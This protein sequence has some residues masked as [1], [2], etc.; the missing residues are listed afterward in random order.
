[1]TFNMPPLSKPFVVKDA[2]TL[3]DAQTRRDG[4]FFA[5]SIKYSKVAILRK[6]FLAY[7]E[8]CNDQK[9]NPLGNMIFKEIYKNTFNEDLPD[10]DQKIKE[11]TLDTALDLMTNR[12][13]PQHH[14]QNL[15]CLPDLRNVFEKYRNELA[16]IDENAFNQYNWTEKKAHIKKITDYNNFVLLDKSIKTTSILDSQHKNLK[17]MATQLEEIMTSMQSEITQFLSATFQETNNQ[18]NP[19]AITNLE[20]FFYTISKAFNSAAED[21]NKHNDHS[22]A[23]AALVN[24]LLKCQSFQPKVF[25]DR[26]YPI[27]VEA[28]ITSGKPVLLDKLLTRAESDEEGYQFLHTAIKNCCFVPYQHDIIAEITKVLLQHNQPI[29]GCLPILAERIITPQETT[30]ILSGILNGIEKQYNNILSK[31]KDKFLIPEPFAEQ[32]RSAKTLAEK[33]DALAA[34]K[35]TITTTTTFTQQIDAITTLQEQ[36]NDFLTALHVNKTNIYHKNDIEN[37]VGTAQKYGF[38]INRHFKE[39]I[40]NSDMSSAPKNKTFDE[41][42]KLLHESDL[43]PHENSTLTYYELLRQEAD[44]IAAVEHRQGIRVSAE[45][46][47]SALLTDAETENATSSVLP[48]GPS[49]SQA[50]AAYTA[51]AIGWNTVQR[52]PQPSIAYTF[53]TTNIKALARRKINSIVLQNSQR[54]HVMAH[55]PED[56]QEGVDLKAMTDKSA[57][58]VMPG[59][60]KNAILAVLQNPNIFTASNNP[61]RIIIQGAAPIPLKGRQKQTVGMTIVCKKDKKNPG[62]AR[63]ITAY[64]HV[65]VPIPEQPTVMS[66]IAKPLSSL[67][68]H[69]PAPEASATASQPPQQSQ[70]PR[71]HPHLM[72]PRRKSH[73]T[74]APISD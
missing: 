25:F 16:K 66:Q 47:Y 27:F 57:H 14:A 5:V 58:S 65:T 32:F 2:Y 41:I 59:L 26:Y 71:I 18:R 64:P 50:A 43:T 73:N 74:P 70:T 42:A 7:M 17:K 44:S 3:G 67:S 56:N 19:P 53:N 72:P 69:P 38:F 33:I 34:F 29:N 23:R 6:A 11:E 37:I 36:M 9:K 55:F 61:E 54:P 48:D 49:T 46:L 45:S 63:V 30:N 51:N 1:M 39:S 40:H 24:T 4:V 21:K 52:P 13:N 15:F 22:R 31:I 68:L 8:H 62:R 10:S 20:S 28:I 12:T 35:E 60:A